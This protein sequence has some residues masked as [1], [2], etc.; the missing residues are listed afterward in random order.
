MKKGLHLRLFVVLLSMT[1]LVFALFGITACKDNQQTGEHEHTFNS[2][3]TADG[4]SHWHQ[5]TCGH[6]EVSD[7]APHNW[8][9]DTSK[10][11][12]ASCIKA[13]ENVF[14]CSVCAQEK[15]EKSAQL[16]HV[17]GEK[18]V[19]K[20]T[21]AV[22]GY[23][24]R[25]CTNEGCDA[26]QKSD[27]T[28]ATGHEFVLNA[29]ECAQ[30][31]CTVNGK[32][33]YK[34]KNCEESYEE[35]VKALGH[36]F[37]AAT[38]TEA[39]V[40][41]NCG[42]K[43]AAALGHTY[44]L[45]AENS[46]QATCTQ[47]GKKVYTCQSCNI[48]YETEE[49][50]LGHLV[51]WDE[52]TTDEIA[53]DN[54]DV[55]YYIVKTGRCELCL[56]DISEKSPVEEHHFVSSGIREVATC[57]RAG[58]RLLTCSKCGESST[59]SYTDAD[60]HSWD[61]G[62][63]ANNITTYTCAHDAQHTKKTVVYSTNSAT[64]D[65]QTLKQAGSVTLGGTS[66]A[67]DS[68]AQGVL[69]GLS[70]VDMGADALTGAALD[71][72]LAALGKDSNDPLLNG[73]V[74][75]LTMTN[76]GSPITDFNGTVT[77][78]IPYELAEGENPDEIVVCYISGNKVE[79][80]TGKY[81]GGYVIFQT[82]H[83]SYYTVTR[84]SPEERC[85]QF[86][87]SYMNVIKD[88]TCLLS[89]YKLKVCTR[90]GDSEKEI[91][92]SLGHEWKVKSESAATCT[93]NGVTAYYCAQCN[94][95]YT[96]ELA[97]T[98]HDW[99]L[100]TVNP[101]CTAAGSEKGV[102]SVCGET[103]TVT[104]AQKE[105]GFT[106]TVTEPTCTEAGFTTNVCVH[107]GTELKNDYKEAL[108]HKPVESTVNPTC[109]EDGYT[110]SHCERCGVEIGEKKDIKKALGHDIIGGVC[111]RCGEGCNHNYT[112]TTV[113]A[114]CTESGYTLNSCT[115]CSN[116]YK[117]DLTDALGHSFTVE[118][119]ERCHIPNPELKDYY[120]NLF[121]NKFNGS[122]A[123]TVNDFSFELKESTVEKNE[124]LANMKQVDVSK[125]SFSLAADGEI[126]GA[127]V[128]NITFKNDE[129]K[130][131]AACIEIYVKG[132]NLYLFTESDDRN[133]LPTT[134][135]MVTLDYILGNM[136][137]GMT[138]EK[139]KGYVTWLNTDFKAVADGLLNT[140]SDVVVK[141]LGTVINY[142]FDRTTE[143]GNYVYTLN[144]DS[145]KT[146][147]DKLYNTS[148]STLYDD[149]FG[150]GSYDKI[151]TLV[152][153]LIKYT[154]KDAIAILED[155]GLDMPTVYA[156][157]DAFM[158]ITKGENIDSA[159]MLE[160]MIKSCVKEDGTPL[161]I[162]DILAAQNTP[163]DIEALKETLGGLKESTPYELFTR[164]VVK[165]EQE[166]AVKE[167]Y[168]TLNGMLDEYLPTVKENLS[169]SFTT[170]ARG[171]LIS[172]YASFNLK[173]L[174]V[175]RNS[176]T[177][178]TVDTPTKPAEGEIV[179][180]EPSQYETVVYLSL[181]GKLSFS[182]GGEVK[183]DEE[184]INSA[185]D[186]ISFDKNKTYEI[187]G[188]ETYAYF[189]G[190]FFNKFHIYERYSNDSIN[191]V[192]DADGYIRTACK[193]SVNTY[194]SVW[195]TTSEYYVIRETTYLQTYNYSFP[196]TS[197]LVM[198]QIGYCGNLDSILIGNAEYASQSER[199]TKTLYVSRTTGEIVNST[200]TEQTTEPASYYN[201]SLSL[202][203]DTQTKAFLS[204]DPHSSEYLVLDEKN[205]KIECGGYYVYACK[206]CDYSIKYEISH[207]AGEDIVEYKFAEGATDCEQGV[208]ATHICPH[209]KEIEYTE[210]ITYH[211]ELLKET[212]NLSDYGSKC[213]DKLYIDSCLCGKREYYTFD[214]HSSGLYVRPENFERRYT[215]YC[216]ENNERIEGELYTCTVSDC[217]F[218]FFYYTEDTKDE[219]CLVSTK[220]TVIL[221]VKF[222]HESEW[223]P[224]VEGGTKYKTVNS[225]GKYYSHDT[226]RKTETTENGELETLV[227]RDCG[228]LLGKTLSSVVEKGGERLE[229]MEYWKY[230]EDGKI[231]SH[232]LYSETYTL[233]PS[234]EYVR[235]LEENKYFNVDDG[236]VYSLSRVTYFCVTVDEKDYVLVSE[237]YNE[238]GS[239][240]SRNEYSYE[241]GI[242]CRVTRT[243]T[244]SYNNEPSVYVYD[245]HQTD[246]LV[247]EPTCTQYGYSQCVFCKE[248]ARNSYP[249]GHSYDYNSELGLYI[250][251]RCG[252][253]TPVHADGDVCLEDLSYTS[254]E[255]YVI[256]YFCWT[257]VS[258]EARVFLIGEQEEHYFSGLVTANS[259][260]GKDES[261]TISFA[262]ADI[263]SEAQKLGLTDYTIRVRLL[264][265]SG[266]FEL[267]YSITIDAHKW[268][269]IQ[270]YEY[271]EYESWYYGG[272]GEGLPAP[273]PTTVEAC[274]ECWL[275]Q[276]YGWA[277][278]HGTD[279]VDFGDKQFK[280]LY[281]NGTR[282]LV[283]V[284]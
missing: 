34:C 214:E 237:R 44:A 255:N 4:E 85:R 233:R 53:R 272:K 259:N 9:L 166:G 11:T 235:T 174:P 152:G 16:T 260:Q 32:N 183:V 231:S 279:I 250:C 160:E 40:C 117:T 244:D 217:G 37:S 105:H 8:Q 110:I 79:S 120:L 3:W 33:V 133:E 274:P 123:L 196:K 251:S 106:K 191:V 101:T 164:L 184:K 227:C 201:S 145:A 266:A 131:T 70:D 13:G 28:A 276:G 99:V 147:N 78:T 66:I 195:Q 248:L 109:T 42:E 188:D 97:A 83:F 19:V 284:N 192:T 14:K 176:S 263:A 254:K 27:Y 170:D 65:A 267:D 29:G 139:F 22:G 241:N 209:C 63:T 121:G 124:L 49:A 75:N 265:V 271:Y 103:Y 215:E 238:S 202:Y 220:G 138:Y 257:N 38:C 211:K 104:L 223:G 84:M 115:N 41:T 161:T 17:W 136:M 98:G 114:T 15:T 127:G 156:A 6:G 179:V 225:S 154:P 158:Y 177:G 95:A 113:A 72:A 96:V 229:T 62:V 132:N 167:L 24:V 206:K 168:D 270:M 278:S 134:V 130:E 182:F 193:T 275:V 112:Q 80:V 129:V 194:R 36:T 157:V 155:Y 94:A 203:Y 126:I 146:L 181:A 58:T 249:Y 69:T 173:E 199:T 73:T 108:G 218:M 159:A 243:R 30:A 239:G 81:S 247:K 67:L 280:L 122:F 198:Y 91:L 82:T 186:L 128:G 282:Y 111:S 189:D 226:E 140:N 20:A 18:T 45:N 169:F 175:G 93:A 74:Y 163:I 51:M 242:Y 54:A 277:K 71:E 268:E 151:P 10:S 273:T 47:N 185:L 246:G 253:Q 180:A 61:G 2:E 89:G 118:E 87:H 234:G 269:Q 222:N 165:N 210:N 1:A 88:A 230:E 178:G 213:D 7:K 219:N 148:I 197:S 119:C 224:F 150:A 5:S 107:C 68:A 100:E 39:Q 57:S 171:N 190:E 35:S 172:M 56:E 162:G 245:E 26:E 43:G 232:S 116:T 221:G 52:T 60:A 144:F 59:E 21:C 264:P 216:N 283:S 228:K 102:C 46:T 90:C 31:T 262:V 64:V 281:V 135:Q 258:F 77:V 50:A 204:D 125:L 240:W 236:T 208:I 76:N 55:C 137:P 252:L 212:I 25:H 256:G 12:A 261:G 153:N 141:A 207:L 149:A 23:S 187:Y 86:G 142:V 48:S 205:S 92:P 143:G 200:V